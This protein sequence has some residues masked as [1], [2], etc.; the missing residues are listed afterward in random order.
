MDNLVL[1]TLIF[2]T[3]GLLA[4]VLN[5]AVSYCLPTRHKTRPWV[6]VEEPKPGHA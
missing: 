4:I 2:G 6:R 3:V 5:L 1:S